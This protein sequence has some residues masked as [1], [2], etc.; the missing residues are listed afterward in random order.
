VTVNDPPSASAPP[1]ERLPT[2]AE[3]IAGQVG[4]W[5]GMVE[6]GIPV[7]VFI[8]VNMVWSVRPAVL[9]S[10]ALALLIAGFRLAQRRPVRYA[11]NGLFGIALGAIIAWR[12]GEARGFY[13]PGIFISYGYAAAMIISVVMRQPLV[14]WLW[15]ILFAGGSAE[16]RGDRRLARTF[17]WLTLLWAA[18]WIAKVSA[19]A[20]L[21]LA[22]EE[23][24]L[25]VARL[26][27][28]TPPYLLLLAITIW[29]VRR[30]ERTRPAA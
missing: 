7:V 9:A 15:S 19:Q 10:V 20:G 24:L 26:V 16:W 29:V 8:V 17:A 1:D 12:T 6:A 11:L 3:Q 21:Y 28:G 25:G 23:H 22:D 30:V 5:R 27:L 2:F 14:G 13:L 18:V 4:G